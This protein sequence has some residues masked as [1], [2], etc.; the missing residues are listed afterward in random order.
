MAPSVITVTPLQLV[1]CWEIELRLGSWHGLS[2]L[3]M[4][5]AQD[6]RVDIAANA[7]E[8]HCY[9]IPPPVSAAHA[10]F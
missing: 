9:G 2:E 4:L 3:T 1:S 5:Q 8:R 6:E 7:F 10:N